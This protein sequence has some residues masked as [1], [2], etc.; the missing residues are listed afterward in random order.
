MNFFFPFM[1]LLV[2]VAAQ[3]TIIDDITQRISPQVTKLGNDVQG[4]PNSG[5][6]GALVGL[7]GFFPLKLLMSLLGDRFRFEGLGN[8]LQYCHKERKKSGVFQ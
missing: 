4:F 6:N 1:T 8:C 7:L 5:L 2:G 3:S